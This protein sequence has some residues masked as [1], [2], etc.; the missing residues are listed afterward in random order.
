M[1]IVFVCVSLVLLVPACAAA[2][3]TVGWLV[4]A[5]WALVFGLAAGNGVLCGVLYLSIDWMRSQ[6]KASP[7]SRSPS[8]PHRAMGFTS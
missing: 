3:V 1:R 7:G 4:D 6:S 2:G 8:G 5:W